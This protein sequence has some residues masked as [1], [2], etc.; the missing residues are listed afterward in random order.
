MVNETKFN[1]SNSKLTKLAEAT[2]LHFSRNFRDRRNLFY[3][4]GVRNFIQAVESGYEITKIFYS[5]KLLIVTPARQLVRKLRREGITTIKLSPEEFRSISHTEKASGIAAIV[6]QSWTKLNQISPKSGLCWLALEKVRSPGNLGT[7]IR[8][9]EAIGGAGIIFLGNS[10]DPYSPKVIRSTMGT[11]FYQKLVR[12]NH[13]SFQNWVRRHNCQIVGASPE[14]NLDFHKF[15]YRVPTILFLGEERKGLTQNQLDLCHHLVRI[16][17][18]GKADS[19]N[20]GVAG[21]LLLYEIY[22]YRA[23]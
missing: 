21:S 20:L 6:R 10:V 19:L 18:I 15:K 5:G 14:G 7:L 12:T 23:N 16:P 17:M 13:R 9:S 1:S 2:R 22:K 8:T 11:L 3:V 4:E